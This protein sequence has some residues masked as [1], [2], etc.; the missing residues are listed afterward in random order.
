M[1]KKSR[2]KLVIIFIGTALIGL[3][4]AVFVFRKK[5]TAAFETV[6][7]AKADVVLEITSTGRV[8]PAEIIRYHRHL[9]SG[10][11]AE[12]HGR[13]IE[14]DSVSSIRAN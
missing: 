7:V 5:T 8:R 11:C 9:P 4:A 10:E 12:T 13:R 3:V 14:S 6:A 2:R 1:H